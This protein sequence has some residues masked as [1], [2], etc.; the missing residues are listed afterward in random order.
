[1]VP[2]AVVVVAVA[3]VLAIRFV[4]LVV[5]ADEIVQRKTVV[6]R[7][8]VAARVRLAPARLV[9]VARAHEALRKIPDEAAVA[10]PVAAHRVAVLV[11]PLVP[12]RG[13]VAHLIAAGAQ[14]P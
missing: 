4:V 6:R 11:V 12:T 2:R 8:E 5:I 13:E 1:A 3:I 14:I 10:L 9:E 7:D